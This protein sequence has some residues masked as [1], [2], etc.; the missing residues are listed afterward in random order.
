MALGILLSA[1]QLTSHLGMCSIDP[2]C[3]KKRMVRIMPLSHSDLRAIVAAA[4]TIPERASSHILPGGEQTSDEVLQARLYAWCQVSTAGDWQ[5]FQERLSWD[6]LDLTGALSLLAPGV[7]SEQVSLPAWT[8]TLQ[9]ALYL[10]ETMPGGSALV[11]KGQWSCLDANAPLPFEELLAPFVALAQWRFL[12]Q[13]G[14]AA[15]LLTDAAH[16]T[17]QRHLLQVLTSLSMPTLHAEFAQSRAQAAGST[18]QRD[19]RECYRHF[20]QQMYQ[21]GLAALLRTYSV[22][23]RLLVT[24]CDLWVEANV[25]FAQR[26]AADWPDLQRCLEPGTPWV[27]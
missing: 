26:L 12:A 13:A 2:I 20:L 16:L 7:W 25:E 27:R 23:A 22:L 19:D 1:A 11:E 14:T 24:A 8:T 21:G 18:E 9:E 5:R 4:S 10:L 6:G 3:K 17:L 15:D